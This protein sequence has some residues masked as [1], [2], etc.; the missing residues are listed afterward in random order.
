MLTL[1]CMYNNYNYVCGFPLTEVS[2]TSN[3][4]LSIQ[5]TKRHLYS[6]FHV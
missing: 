6:I 3:I 4:K 1:T 5:I 2:T